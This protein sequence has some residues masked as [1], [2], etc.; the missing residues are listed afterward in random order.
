LYGRC[1]GQEGQLAVLDAMLFFSIAGLVASI[2]IC[3]GAGAR[4][5]G[6]EVPWEQECGIEPGDILRAFLR[7]S[8]GE[9]VVLDGAQPLEV[10]P[11]DS[12][13]ECLIA[14]VVSVLGGSSL[15][16][17][18][19]HKVMLR[20]LEGVVPAGWT[21]HLGVYSPDSREPVIRIEACEVPSD[22]AV[23]GGS[24]DVAGPDGSPLLVSL[25]VGPALLPEV[26]GV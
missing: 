9:V 4:L 1:A 8:V 13:A 10:H 24:C 6:E 5:S 23:Y 11:H 7:A 19:V 26:F 2:V 21:P 17:S 18:P 20:A 22:G 3:H 12:M 16:F 14:E 15:D 25:L